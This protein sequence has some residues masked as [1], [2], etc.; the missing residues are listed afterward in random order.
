VGWLASAGRPTQLTGDRSV[1]ETTRREKTI[2]VICLKSR[3]IADT[4]YIK[5][6]KYKVGESVLATYPNDFIAEK[7]L[8]EEVIG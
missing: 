3:Y 2:V 6:K 8:V 1:A 4:R 5:G 7:D